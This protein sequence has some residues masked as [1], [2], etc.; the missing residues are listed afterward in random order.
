[1][2]PASL[3]G[4]ASA[5]CRGA[6]ELAADL[7]QRELALA[8]GVDDRRVELLPASTTIVRWATLQLCAGR[9]GRLL[10]IASSVS[11]TAKM[12]APSGISRSGEAVRSSRCRPSARGASGRRRRL[13]A[14]ERDAAEHLRA[15]HGV[16]L[17]QAPLLGRQRAGLAEH[18]VRDGDLADV[19]QQEPVLERRI[20]G[21]RR[22]VERAA[23]SRA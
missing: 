1:M 13:A 10:V 18:F 17:H 11:A 12:R 6:S 23:S 5:S 21:Q 4:G 15:E 19:V 20:V 14:Q 2:P 8:E 3:P 16:R 22:A 9:Y 7:V